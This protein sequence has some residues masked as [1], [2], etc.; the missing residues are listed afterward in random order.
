[1]F[2]CSYRYFIVI[3]PAGVLGPQ[4]EASSPNSPLAPTWD[5]CT[6]HRGEGNDVFYGTLICWSRTHTLLGQ[7]G[8]RRTAAELTVRNV[9]IV[10]W[11]WSLDST[12]W[13]TFTLLALNFGIVSEITILDFCFKG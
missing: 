8:G 4:N 1:M 3:N 12:A 13:V 9:G 7:G 6:R 10:S 5:L 2:A 11:I